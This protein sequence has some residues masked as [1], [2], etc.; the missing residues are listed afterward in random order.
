MLNAKTTNKGPFVWRICELGLEMIYIVGPYIHRLAR[1]LQRDIISIR[2]I[3]PQKDEIRN[4]QGGV[5]GI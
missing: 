2:I 4:T 1:Q 5:G 3:I